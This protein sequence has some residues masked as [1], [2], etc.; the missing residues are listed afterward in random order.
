[1]LELFSGYSIDTS[2]LIDLWRRYYPP[3]IFPSLWKKLEDLVSKGSL[4][5]THK[6]Y[7]ELKKY[8]DMNDELLKWVKKHK[9]MF[10]NL[11]NDQLTHLSEIIKH[12]PEF[13][14]SDKT[15]PEAD[16][17]VI[18][19][20][21]SKGWTVVT[22]ERPANPGGRLKIP[23]VCEKCNIKS[24]SIIEFFREQGWNF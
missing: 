18:A 8:F 17:F 23:D 2:A 12:Y 3:D 10:R 19:L 22:S 13:V 6:V 7:E 1:M 14:D 24:V 9:K 4:I 21:K 16:P 11:D 15:L 5:A 20:A